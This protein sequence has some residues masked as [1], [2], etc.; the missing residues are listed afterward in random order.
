[1]SIEKLLQ[2]IS[3]TEIKLFNLIP[4]KHIGGEKLNEL[5]KDFGPDMGFTMNPED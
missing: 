3:D 2:I 5:L 4:E 1:M